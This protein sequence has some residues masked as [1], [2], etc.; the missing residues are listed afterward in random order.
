MCAVLMNVSEF[1]KGKALPSIFTF[2]R[3][4]VMQWLTAAKHICCRDAYAAEESYFG[5]PPFLE[6]DASTHW[7]EPHQ[8]YTWWKNNVERRTK[9]K[10]L[11]EDS[12]YA[13][14]DP[15]RVQR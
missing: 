13:G 9:F 1:V 5:G 2:K 10:V 3:D 11:Q 4:L 7:T 6:Q 14:T 8:L 15:R 12:Q